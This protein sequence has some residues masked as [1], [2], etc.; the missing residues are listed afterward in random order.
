MDLY[1]HHW[2]WL[3][4]TWVKFLGASPR[5]HPAVPLLPKPFQSRAQLNHEAK[6]VSKQCPVSIAPCHVVHP[7]SE[8]MARVRWCQK[9]NLKWKL[10]PVKSK[11][12]FSLWTQLIKMD[13]VWGPGNVSLIFA[14]LVCSGM[15]SIPQLDFN[16]HHT[17][18]S[19]LGQV[20]VR[21]TP[22]LKLFL[23]RLEFPRYGNF[24]LK[25]TLIIWS[26][27]VVLKGAGMEMDFMHW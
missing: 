19:S 13:F 9:L 20:T 15:E 18:C 23:E 11:L 12:P 2:H 1:W 25:Q 14:S 17:P 26:V 16:S 24:Y 8:V 4:W 27:L 6:S 5:S 7:C 21:V 22:D 3:H 10:P